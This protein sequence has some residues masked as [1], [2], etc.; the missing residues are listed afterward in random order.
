M[1]RI[2]VDWNKI[3]EEELQEYEKVRVSG[4]TNM[5]AVDVVEDLSGL[6][7]DTIRSIMEHY[8]DLN[9]KYPGVRKSLMPT[10]PTET[11]N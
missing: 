6:D 7:R 3:T 1:E 2:K 5:W 11:G 10:R 9:K 4:V 8:T